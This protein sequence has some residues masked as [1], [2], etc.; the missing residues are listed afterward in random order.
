LKHKIQNR[1]GI[2]YFSEVLAVMWNEDE[3]EEEEENATFVR[4]AHTTEA[5][6]GEDVP[7]EASED[8]LV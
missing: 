1:A 2:T 4:P 5:L 7:T 8:E 6:R 3:D